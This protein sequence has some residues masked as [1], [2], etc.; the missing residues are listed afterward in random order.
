MPD[1][2]DWNDLLAFKPPPRV[3][4]DLTIR[5]GGRIQFLDEGVGDVSLDVFPIKVDRLPDGFKSPEILLSAI[6]KDLNE[7]VDT[8]IT[9]FSFFDNNEEEK[10]K[11]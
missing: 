4:G 8:A 7:F 5:T 9:R 11:K 1:L 6:R 3:Q 2:N 10:E